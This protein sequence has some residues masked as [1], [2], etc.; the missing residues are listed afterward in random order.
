MNPLTDIGQRIEKIREIFQKAYAISTTEEDLNLQVRQFENTEIAYRSIAYEAASMALAVKDFSKGNGLNRWRSFL[1]GPAALHAAQVHAGLGWAMAQQRIP[2][3]PIIETLEPLMRYRM[4]DGWGYYIGIFRQRQ[5]NGSQG[6]PPDSDSRFIQGFDQGVGRSLW[7][8]CKGVWAAILETVAGFSV[9][10]H[11]DLW[12]GI[13]IACSYVG[14]CDEFILRELFSL[15]YP[16]QI[17]LS[18]GAA[19][20]ARSRSSANTNTQDIEL[21]C[22]VWCRRSAQEASWIA[23]NAEPSLSV[24]PN[25]A[26]P[27]WLSN[28]GEK[29]SL[30]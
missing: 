5:T 9:S 7:Y 28:I 19:L 6:F 3:S 17:Q 10:R 11:P 29:L 20:V 1:E 14:G 24:D 12:R 27:I 25:D 18:V 22:Q 4:L 13:G 30:S 15:S 23:E 16:Y 2:V 8:N 26:Y 21:A